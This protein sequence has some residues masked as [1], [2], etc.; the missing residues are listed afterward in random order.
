MEFEEAEQVVPE[1]PEFTRK[2]KLAF[3]RDMLGL[4]VSDH[5]LKGLEVELSKLSARP[6]L[7]LLGDTDVR[8]GEQVQIAGLVTT[9][10]HRVAR[11]SGNPYGIVSIEDFGGEMTVMF[12]GKTYLE[13]RDQ[14]QSDTIAVVRGRAQH[15]DDGLNITAQGITIP[16]LSVG[17]NPPLTLTLADTRAT[18]KV[19]QELD[20][21]LRRN[22]GESEVRIHLETPQSVR[23]FE[24]PHRVALGSAIYS[25]LAALLGP[26]SVG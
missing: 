9:V 18:E 5:P 20:E 8:D 12:L 6:I 21:R 10:Q 11:N 4:Y 13:F 19:V 7:D 16:H 23:M 3:E 25:E 26:G 24:L 15:R 17:D 2:D 14:L 22:Q 1:R